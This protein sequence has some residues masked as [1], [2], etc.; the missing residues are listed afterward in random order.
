M[1][2]YRQGAFPMADPTTPF[3][4]LGWYLPEVRSVIVLDEA[5]AGLV[6][7]PTWRMPRRLR[8]TL[9]SGRFVVTCDR[10]FG[11]VI[12]ACA[13]PRVDGPSSSSDTWIDARIVGLFEQLHAIGL[14]HSVEA[15][16]PTPAGGNELVGGVYGLAVG[17][18]FCAESMFTRRSQGGSDAGKVALVCLARHLFLRGFAVID[19]QFMNPNVERFGAI[20]VDD[21]DYA[22]LLERVAFDPLA[23]GDFDAEGLLSMR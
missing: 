2:L 8:S 23:W 18:V 5:G 19:T 12:R 6:N 3:A 15:W 10:A 7:G 22:E 13:E 1:S 4:D 9:R 14:A 17:G 21:V 16:R 20:E 11:S